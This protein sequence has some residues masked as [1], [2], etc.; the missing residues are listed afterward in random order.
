MQKLSVNQQ[1]FPEDRLAWVR[2]PRE[3]SLWFGRF[4]KFRRMGIT[5]SRI[6]VY[7][8]WIRQ[9]RQDPDY[10]PTSRD[11]EK[12]I[13]EIESCP[14]SWDTK[15]K[16]WRWEER[17][18]LYDRYNYEQEEKQYE[19][20]RVEIQDKSWSLYENLLRR[21]EEMIQYPI[22]EIT[23]QDN[24]GKAIII[25]PVRWTSKDIQS[26]INALK[27]L[28]EIAVM[29]VYNPKTGKGIG[30]GSTPAINQ[31][32]TEHSKHKVLTPIERQG[33]SD[34]DLIEH[35]LEQVVDSV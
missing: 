12:P 13:E 30:G 20:R 19:A 10:A 1:D 17:A 9:S 21:V 5:R 16:E 33:L 3:P 2:W 29:G 11:T 24:D 18:D 32:G 4:T 35:V 28:G 6:K 8:E 14:S 25:K 27:T 7:R 31:E 26:H 22:T 23:T 34:Q 15:A